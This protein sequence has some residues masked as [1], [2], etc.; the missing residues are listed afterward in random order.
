MSD[1]NLTN[2]RNI[3]YNLESELYSIKHKINDEEYIKLNANIKLLF[4]N[5]N[6]LNNLNQ[7]NTNIDYNNLQNRFNINYNSIN[8]DD[9]YFYKIFFINDKHR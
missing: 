1:N 8:N 4:D 7:P 5:I 9:Y 6:N 2:M 3:I